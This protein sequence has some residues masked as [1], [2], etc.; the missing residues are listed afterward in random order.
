MSKRFVRRGVS[1]FLFAPTV[2]DVADVSREDIT[3]ATD[4][5]PEIADIAGWMLENQAAATP[6]MSSTFEKT[7]PGLDSAAD[8]SFTFYE[9]LD[10]N[11]IEVLFAKGT[12]GVVMI[13]RKGDVPESASMDVFSVR[14]GSKGSQFSV[15]NDP[16]RMIVNFSITEEPALDQEIPA[17]TAG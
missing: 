6:D 10:E 7:I 1:K 8:S 9:T 4:I 11:E 5:T 2:S 12:E 15:G 16:A 3:G 14:V 13:L 17:A